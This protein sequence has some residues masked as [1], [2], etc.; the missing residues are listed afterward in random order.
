MRIFVSQWPNAPALQELT[1]TDTILVFGIATERQMVDALN[2]VGAATVVCEEMPRWSVRVDTR[3]QFMNVRCEVWRA[4]REIIIEGRYKLDYSWFW[5][6]EIH[7]LHVRLNTPTRWSCKLAE[8]DNG[9]GREPDD[10][11][12]RR[13]AKKGRC[14]KKE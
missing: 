3:V 13:R 10:D 11:I 2:G 1:M 9:D 5:T 12:E 6:P 8:A 4:L 7:D 14:D